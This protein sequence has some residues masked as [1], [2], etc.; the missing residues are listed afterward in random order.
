MLACAAGL[1][2]TVP[3]ALP[4]AAPAKTLRDAATGFTVKAPADFRLGH[5]AK[6][7]AYAISS[8]RRHARVSYVRFTTTQA[9]D[10]LAKSYLA[11]IGAKTVTETSAAGS[12]VA[13]VTT[14]AGKAEMVEGR[15]D[16]AGIDL[17][18]WGS[19]RKGHAASAAASLAG[20]LAGIARSATGGQAIAVPQT[21]HEVPV[22]P[23][24][25]R[26]F[27]NSDGS[28]KAQVPADPDFSCS[29]V[30]GTVECYGPRGELS[31]GLG[32]PVCPPGSTVAQYAA[33]SPGLCPVIAPFQSSA[34]AVVSVWPRVR[35]L[36]LGGGIANMTVKQVIPANIPGYESALYIASFTRDGAPWT[37]AFLVGVT[38]ATGSEQ[39][40]FYFSD[41]AVPGTDDSS[42]SQ[43][44][45]ATWKSWDPSAAI[46]QRIQA[47]NQS[48]KATTETIQS[49][50]D[51]RQQVADQAAENWD[52]YIRL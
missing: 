43:A 18:V 42:V 35:N 29:G 19:T 33:L 12:Y 2:I 34:N 20:I 32:L 23:I 39:W 9:P 46:D 8:K 31:L 3:A 40:L 51:F 41:M 45:L 26:P 22:A 52:G 30:K 4:A 13:K 25:L 5:S 16:G 28:A 6:T 7:G 44:L 10:A 37:G 48:I 27:V 47:T 38:P 50:N 49:V 14:K 1:A 21:T 11:A 36:V 17:I 15:Q 24:A